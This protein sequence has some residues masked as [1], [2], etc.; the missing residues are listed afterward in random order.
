MPFCDFFHIITNACIFAQLLI[1]E[2]S[3]EL[4]ITKTDSS[5]VLH[6]VQWHIA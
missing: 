1:A 2:N 6:Y 5:R 3:K 4:N